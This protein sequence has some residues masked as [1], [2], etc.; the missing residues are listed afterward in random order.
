M[1]SWTDTV[2]DYI[3]SGVR[4]R[5]FKRL[6]TR[7]AQLKDFEKWYG[8]R[9]TEKLSADEETART[10]R[11]ILNISRQDTSLDD[12]ER[13]NLLGMLVEIDGDSAGFLPG[14]LAAGATHKHGC[15]SLMGQTV[16]TQ[17]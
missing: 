14:L 5:P 6:K 9:A 15:C 4:L 17:F 7:C 8:N 10:A 2:L 13:L 11:H 1:L 16:S 3:F 12:R